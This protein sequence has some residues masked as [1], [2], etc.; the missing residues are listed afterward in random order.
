MRLCTILFLSLMLSTAANAQ[1]TPV[2]EIPFELLPSG[3][4]LVKA[5]VNGITG[6]FLFDTGA[7]ITLFTKSFFNKLPWS[8]R[9]DGGYTGF[10]ATGERLDL[11][12]YEV[13]DF[14][15]GTIKKAREEVSW[16]DVNLGGIDG[17]ISLKLLEAWP[18]TIDFRKNVLRLD[19]SQ[20][21]A[22]AEKTA[23]SLPLQLEQ[24]RNKALTIFTYFRVND[25]L[26][27]QFSLDSGAGKDIYRIHARY[28]QQLGVNPADSLQVQHLQKQS[29]F[30]P[31]H[32]T[33]IYTTTLPQLA[34]EKTPAVSVRNI[35]VQYV[36][37]L[38]YDGII[39]LNWLGSV[40]TFDLPRQRLL[41]QR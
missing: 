30:N 15:L 11:D 26:T 10:R 12:L 17:I 7:G 14:Q 34:A 29:E 33:H 25:S 28:M 37:D 20:S 2:S 27:L 24:S 6:S 18:F 19:N 23:Y 9:K 16:L 21:L 8:K 40:I 31:A 35:P 5:T 41:V 3:H 39:W 38:I 22:T 4:L 36:D 32:V 1:Q 13:K